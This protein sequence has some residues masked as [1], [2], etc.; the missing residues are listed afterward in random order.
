MRSVLGTVLVLALAACKSTIEEA[1]V[2]HGP[3]P[4]ELVPYAEQLK[5]AKPVTANEL[6]RVYSQGLIEGALPDQRFRFRL[7]H[8]T[9]I[10]NGTNRR[11]PGRVFLELRTPAESAF[12]YALLAQDDPLATLT[13]GTP[14]KLLCHGAGAMA[15]SPLL[16]DCRRE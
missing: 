8:V 16:K 12:V 5:D 1:P 7:L 11:L 2:Q 13:P 4:L 6:Y 10:V 9:G 14:V 15:G 3:H